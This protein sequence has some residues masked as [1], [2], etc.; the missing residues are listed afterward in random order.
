M[1]T[2]VLNT[3]SVAPRAANRALGAY[4]QEIRCEALRTVRNPGLAIP[5]LLM[6]V[7]LY[8]LFTMVVT[9]DAIDRDP[10]IGIFLF[11]AF[12]IMGATMPALFGIGAT[13]AM[14]REM[15]LLR[16]KRAQPAPVAGWL[17]AKIVCGVGFG[18]LSY[19]PIALLALLSG[20]IALEPS[21]IF[22]M[23]LVLIAC[24]IPFCAM[25]LMVGALVRGSAAPGYANLFYLP[26]CYL[27]GMF[28]PLP[29]SMHWQA[30]I[31]PQFHVGQL[32]MHAA[33]VTKFQFMPAQMSIAA[34]VGFT[35]LFSAIAV[36]R[37]VSKG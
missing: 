1:N 10:S 26:G 21:Q 11:S 25:G 33:D 27:S 36:W 28:F 2:Q 22:A 14:E 32:A 7:A 17:V 9:A 29:Q 30:P 8:A 19:A 24:S 23:S 20:K 12:S 37:M 31:W 16:L 34:L 13:L 15:G 5:V 4:L 35:V 3:L 18:V 6:P